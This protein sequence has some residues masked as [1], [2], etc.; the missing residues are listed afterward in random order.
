MSSVLESYLQ[1]PH[2]QQEIDDATRKFLKNRAGKLQPGFWSRLARATCG[3]Q[4]NA[5]EGM[6]DELLD[7]AVSEMWVQ[8]LDHEDEAEGLLVQTLR[9]VRNGDCAI[10]DLWDRLFTKAFAWLDND[11]REQA[12]NAS[13]W[14]RYRKSVLGILRKSGSF[15]MDTKVDRQGR[16]GPRTLDK[17]SPVFGAEPGDRFSDIPVPRERG[18]KELFR[19]DKLS[20][21][22][23]VSLATYFWKAVIA[24]RCQGLP[25][26]VPLNAFFNWLSDNYGLNDMMQVQPAR[27]GDDDEADLDP[28]DNLRS[29]LGAPEQEQIVED[30]SILARDFARGLSDRE[31]IYCA[32]RYGEEVR[33]EDLAQRL[34]YSSPSGLSRLDRKLME[35]LRGCVL[36]QEEFADEEDGGGDLRQLFLDAV[37]DECKK[38]AMAP[39]G[40]AG[41]N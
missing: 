38:L 15:Y 19:N 29:D 12:R 27:G 30:V 39:K 16:Y 6:T 32:L 18:R 41:G 10:G 31:Q 17:K 11:V 21:E 3:R 14:S 4:Q 7:T 22:A 34:G 2:R 5:G 8:I 36:Q 28:L 25:H 37:V 35:R 33:L 13:A 40:E 23:V 1:D 24:A 20:G 9:D 26:Q